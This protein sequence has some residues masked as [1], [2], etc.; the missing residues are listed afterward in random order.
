MDDLK[1]IVVFIGMVFL[2]LFSFTMLG[3]S[4]ESILAN[5]EPY[6]IVRPTNHFDTEEI[7]LKSIDMS[8]NERVKKP[9]ALITQSEETIYGEEPTF[10][11]I[12][13]GTYHEIDSLKC[14][15]YKQMQWK[16]YHLD[17]LNEKSCE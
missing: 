15:R 7:Y 3:K 9:Y 10:E 6:Q 1:K 2:L 14:V 17:K 12:D 4:Q 16:L 8:M 11:T 13:Y 5:Y